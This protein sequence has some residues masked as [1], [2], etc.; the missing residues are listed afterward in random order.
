[1][2]LTLITCNGIVTLIMD[3]NQQLFNLDLSRVVMGFNNPLLSNNTDMTKEK[4]ILISSSSIVISFPHTP[5]PKLMLIKVW[6]FPK[7]NT[8]LE[9]LTFM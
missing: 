5:E 8:F 1:M 4:I 6:Y 2:F 3:I 7:G 9:C